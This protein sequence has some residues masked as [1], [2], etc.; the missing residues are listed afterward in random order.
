MKILDEFELEGGIAIENYS[1]LCQNVSAG[2]ILE[3]TPCTEGMSFCADGKI[4]GYLFGDS[5]LLAVYAYNNGY[6]IFARIT[7]VRRVEALPVLFASL[8]AV[9]RGTVWGRE[10][11]KIEK[12]SKE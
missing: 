5:A 6:G 1:D 9:H 2:D 11:D 7:S 10:K 3:G 8:H 4:L 12:E